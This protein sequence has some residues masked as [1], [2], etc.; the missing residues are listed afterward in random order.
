[1]QKIW[2]HC[3]CLW[4][5]FSIHNGKDLLGTQ[6][7]DLWTPAL[8]LAPFT[9]IYWIKVP[10]EDLRTILDLRSVWLRSVCT[11][12]WHR[13]NSLRLHGLRRKQG[14]LRSFSSSSIVNIEASLGTVD[15]SCP[16]LVLS[17]LVLNNNYFICVF[18][19]VN[20]FDE[21][22]LS[23][24]SAWCG[25]LFFNQKRFFFLLIL[26]MASHIAMK[27]NIYKECFFIHRT[28]N[29]RLNSSLL[30]FLWAFL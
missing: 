3:P 14:S 17:D 11:E 25:W 9:K 29:V 1:M 5:A 7:L 28:A 19:R 15:V 16:F 21:M 2:Q 23:T 20:D 10:K 30:N 26:I 12:S 8:R 4:K 13:Y 18:S 22:S 6:N 27:C 24:C